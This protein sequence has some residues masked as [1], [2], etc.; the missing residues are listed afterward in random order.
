MSDDLN[1]IDRDAMVRTVIG[2]AGNQGP[3]GQAAVAQSIMNRVVSGRYGNSP[4]AVVLAPG[5]YEPW[6][7]RRQ[8]LLSYSPTSPAYQKVGGIVDAVASG[9][10]PDS[11]NGAT[12]FLNPAVVMQRRGSLPGLG[13]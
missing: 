7:T 9:E 3:E 6:Q 12:H 10:I 13:F 5:Q 4:A 8:E 2:E 11:T 1:P